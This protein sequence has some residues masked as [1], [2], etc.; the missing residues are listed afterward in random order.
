[1]IESL[2][3]TYSLPPI[4]F[5]FPSACLL[6]F[7]FSM[8][9]DGRSIHMISSSMTQ[10]LLDD[11]IKSYNIDPQFKSILPL[12][13]QLM[14]DPPSG[15]VGVYTIFF[16]S[17][18]RLRAFDF[19]NSTL[20]HYKLHIS[21]IGPN[22]FNK[23]MCLVIL[24]KS[25]NIILTLSVFHHFYVMMVNNERVLFSFC[26]SSTEICDNLLFSLRNGNLI[27]FFCGCFCIWSSCSS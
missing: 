24:N 17:G 5:F 13:N 8:E 19:L 18:L 6:H 15:Y 10:K 26:H 7:R 11:F 25:L 2:V 12:V 22:G 9:K 4:S 27:S 20:N 23:I 21:Q 3:P 1:M 14:I 16:R